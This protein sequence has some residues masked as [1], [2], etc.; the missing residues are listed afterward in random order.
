MP[1]RPRP[2]TSRLT[3]TVKAR[4]SRGTSPGRSRDRNTNIYRVLFHEI[5]ERGINEAMQKPSRIDEH[6]VNSQQAR[7]AMDRL[8]GYKV[9]PFVWKTVYYGLSAGRV[10]S[11][12]VRLICEREEEVTLVHPAGVLVHHR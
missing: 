9:S 5:T 6:L 4:R 12:A 3:L 8:V 10:Q 11:V 2:S 1:P 7:R